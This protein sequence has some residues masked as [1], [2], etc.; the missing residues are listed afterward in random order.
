MRFI[1][2]H[3][4]PI[5]VQ[6][7]ANRGKVFQFITTFGASLSD[8]G[9]SSEVLSREENRLLVE[10]KTPISM[11]FR[12]QK[13]F[14]TVERVILHEPESVDFEE[15]EGPFAMRRERIILQEEEG[16]THLQY[17]ADLGMKGWIF[18]WL[19]GM[20]FVRPRLKRA[21][22]EHFRTIK[23]TIEKTN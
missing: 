21:V 12:K 8:V 20:L 19:L 18:G 13:I 22:Q 11:P 14:R 6:I 2:I 9:A 17:E 3:M 5:E 15:V 7:N 4:L 23:E 16:K 10:F 1:P